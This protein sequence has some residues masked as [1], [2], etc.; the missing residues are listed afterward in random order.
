M[1]QKESDQARGHSHS[2]HDPQAGDCRG[3]DKWF[4]RE[5]ERGNGCDFRERTS[6]LQMYRG[7]IWVVLHM[8]HGVQSP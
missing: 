4:R 7:Q 8:A 6:N 2:T 1:T 3:K 5:E